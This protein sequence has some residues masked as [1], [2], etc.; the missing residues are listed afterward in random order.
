MR[1]PKMVKNGNKSLFTTRNRPC[2]PFGIHAPKTDPNSK[3]R[4]KTNFDQ[5]RNR[6]ARYEGSRMAPLHFRSDFMF[7]LFKVSGNLYVCGWVLLGDNWKF[8][9][10]YN[11]PETYV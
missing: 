2:S 5:F 6:H 8:T 11:V 10:D 1:V 9:G 4:I 7:V 3:R